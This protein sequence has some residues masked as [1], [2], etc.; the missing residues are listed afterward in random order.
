MRHRFTPT[1][2]AI[3]LTVALLIAGYGFRSRALFAFAVLVGSVFLVGWFW[4]RNAM[5]G[6]TYRRH[7]S[8]TR[9]F[10]G[11]TV[12]VTLT[13]TNR[14]PLPLP[15]VRL[16]DQVSANL[17]FSDLALETSHIP[18]LAQIRQDFALS[19]FDEISRTFQLECRE[20]GIFDFTQAR[21]ETG[22]PFDLFPLNASV[23]QP[24]RLIIYP[25][26]KPVI[27][28]DLPNKEPLGDRV[29]RRPI[30]EDPIYLRG[31]REYQPQ[32]DIRHVHWKA[33]ARTDALQ[34]KVF[35]PTSTP[36]LMLFVN[37][38]TFART[39]EGIDP[40]LLER[41]VSV[42]ASICAYAVQLRL[43]V[44]LSANGTLPRSD[45]PLRV[46]SS[47]SPQQ[48]TR[49]LEALAAVRGVAS[50]NFENFLLH[51]S[52]RLPWGATLM[53][54]TAVVTPELEMVLLRLKDAG[55]RLVLLSLEDKPPRWIRGVLTY[56]LP[57]R[58]EDESFHFIP[59]SVSA[60]VEA[61]GE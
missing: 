37:V 6:L 25:E 1:E 58:A 21:L 18:G 38:A 2:R 49:L 36:S 50:G 26:V 14:K 15:R 5:R 3:F 55:R 35:E 53:I 13:L 20:R 17:V 24:D 9:A 8:E 27:G 11:E 19:W 43:M 54:V 29:V 46:S 51:N 47:R 56:H 30:F 40:I 4:Q 48:L 12:E 44:G 60:E 39:W 10:V 7:F 61:G 16:I 22:D 28:L 45:Q 41:V 59:V 31:V 57:G 23:G 33:T 52:T 34:T 32:D 42:A